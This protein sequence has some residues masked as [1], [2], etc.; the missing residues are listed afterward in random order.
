MKRDVFVTRGDYINIGTKNMAKPFNAL[1]H[2]VERKIWILDL[3]LLQA[4]LKQCK[5]HEVNLFTLHSTSITVKLTFDLQHSALIKRYVDAA[6]ESINHFTKKWW[7]FHAKLHF[8]LVNLIQKLI[9]S[10]IRFFNKN[11][12]DGSEANIE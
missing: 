5:R 1:V 10:I 3:H 4:M 7:K 11:L 12:A 8:D 6:I 2:R 9:Y